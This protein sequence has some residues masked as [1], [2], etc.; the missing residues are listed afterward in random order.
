MKI[1]HVL[2]AL[3]KGGGERVTA[4]LANH[5]A[6]AGHDV[7]VIA[8]CPVDSILLRDA[9]HPD[10][11]VRYVTDLS[12]HSRMGW[13]L[14]TPP[15]LLRHRSWL[16]EQDILHCHL[17]YGAVFGTAVAILRSVLGARRPVIVETYHAVGMP[18]PTVHRWVHARLAA[19]RDALAVMAED[20]YWRAFLAARPGL[21]SAFI[22]NG[23]SMSTDDD[24]DHDM[25][26][27][28]RREVGIPD[29]CRFVIG[30]V[31]RLE[32]DRQPWRYVPIFAEIAR[33]LGPQVR[34]IIGGGGSELDRMR[35][36]VS[37]RGLM[38]QIHLPGLVIRPRLPLS[39]MNLYVTLNVG[40]V[41]GM[42]ALE[43]AASG[44]PVLGIQMLDKY[45]PGPKDW[46][47]SSADLS[48]VATRAIELLRS[49][50]EL[51]ALAERQRAYVRTHHTTEA[52]ACSY[53]TLYQTA[54]ERSR[55]KTEYV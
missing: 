11:R 54:A 40:A 49:P 29:D 30:T 7:T 48:A 15:W 17:T 35:S 28:Y 39:I 13:Y 45:Q 4:E 24:V 36:L 33:V 50:T 6:Q 43:A 8:A 20:E 44:V 47:W 1:V 53:N 3:I 23:T 34:F 10:V 52:M 25:R 9:L 32:P 27:A 2:P 18:I 12:L 16:L 14:R 55:S 38:G 31:G 26:I 37:E 41:T 22:P 42:A 5:A 46:I 51:K 19:R 21:V